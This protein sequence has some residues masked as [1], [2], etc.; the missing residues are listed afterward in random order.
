MTTPFP[1]RD[2]VAEES[3]LAFYYR[4]MEWMMEAVRAMMMM[5]CFVFTVLLAGSLQESMLAKVSLRLLFCGAVVFYSGF[6]CFLVY[7]VAIRAARCL[8]FV[9][10]RI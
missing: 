1:A 3:T 2:V 10:I 9:V 7:H 4:R 5:C 6:G 8:Q